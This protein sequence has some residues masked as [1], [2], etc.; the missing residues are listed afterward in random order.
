[1]HWA[2]YFILKGIFLLGL[3]Q[4]DPVG[5][6]PNLEYGALLSIAFGALW[7]AVY[8]RFLNGG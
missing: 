8:P 1:M 7:G 3:I 6:P 4:L 2:I 5:A